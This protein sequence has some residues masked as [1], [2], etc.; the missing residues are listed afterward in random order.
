MDVLSVGE[1]IE[2]LAGSEPWTEIYFQRYPKS[3]MRVAKVTLPDGSGVWYVDNTNELALAGLL[4]SL[5]AVP[6]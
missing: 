3:D 1:Q 6:A 2:A 4:K 5:Q